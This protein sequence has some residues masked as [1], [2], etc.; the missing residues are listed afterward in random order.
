[1]V[2]F[3]V[4]MGVERVDPQVPWVLV[5]GEFREQVEAGNR[6]LLADRAYVFVQ[7]VKRIVD[8]LRVSAPRVP[9]R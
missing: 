7:I 5:A 8:A 3:G 2:R 1:M 9:E 4:R 6:L